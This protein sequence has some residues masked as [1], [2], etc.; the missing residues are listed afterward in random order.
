MLDV[1]C[2]TGILSLFAAKVRA[3]T[4]CPLSPRRADSAAAQTGAKHVYAV[5]CSDIAHTAREIVAANGFADKI[6][7][8][9]GKVEE[10][11][12]PVEKV[13]IIVSEWMGYFVRAPRPHAQRMWLR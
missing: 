10:V 9:K 4:L 2:G 7:V 3:A 1:G 8:I 6:T 11:T 12:L 13:D 5:E